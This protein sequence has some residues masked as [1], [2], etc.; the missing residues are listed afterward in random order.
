M[1]IH[2]S[3]F[4]NQLEFEYIW[5]GWEPRT[6]ETEITAISYCYFSFGK[7][8]RV[9]F[10][11]MNAWEF[12]SCARFLAAILCRIILRMER[13][14]FSSIGKRKSLDNLLTYQIV[15]FFYQMYIKLSK[16]YVTKLHIPSNSFSVHRTVYITKYLNLLS[17]WKNSLLWKVK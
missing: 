11:V 13:W 2:D 10:T 7:K 6:L 8:G 4:V 12:V 3:Q 15:K 14:S 9:W 5:K 17:S 1:S 16:I